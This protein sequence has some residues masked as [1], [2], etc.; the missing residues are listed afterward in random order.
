MVL[1]QNPLLIVNH[2]YIWYTTGSGKTLSTLYPAIKYLPRKEAKI[3]YLVSKGTQKQAAAEAL[4]ILERQG[5]KIKALILD[6]KEKVCLNDTV[7]CNPEQCV[8]AQGYYD[9]VRQTVQKIITC[10]S[11]LDGEVIQKY[12]KKHRMCPFELSLDVSR[13]CDVVICDYNYVFDPF[14][15]LKRYFEEKGDY[16]FLI[17]EAHNLSQRGRQMYSTTLSKREIKKGRETLK[18]IKPLFSALSKIMTAYNKLKKNTEEE[19]AELAFS[20]DVFG[21]MRG[22][23]RT[24]EEYSAKNGELPE[25]IKEI[26]L[27]ILRFTKLMEMATEGHICYYLK[28][29]ERV[30]LSCLDASS[31][32]RAALKKSFS[33]ILFSA[34]YTPMAYFMRISGGELVGERLIGC[35]VVSVGLPKVNYEKEKLRAYYDDRGESGFDYAY[36]YEGINKVTQAAGRL[37]RTESDKGAILL[38]DR[39]FAQGKYKELVAQNWPDIR[40]ISGREQ[41]NELLR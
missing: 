8:Y 14:V 30:C 17:D 32:L 38:L 1:I 10:E 9:K 13:F 33:A 28:S 4:R 7:A 3:F 26:Y 36:L 21:R 11:L 12:A 31:Y 40:Y 25:E 24:A 29:E 23:I 2:G 27:A 35:A 15:S 19:I 6:A 22:F 18:H 20:D 41:L 34:T 37:I 39:R 5:L 16:V